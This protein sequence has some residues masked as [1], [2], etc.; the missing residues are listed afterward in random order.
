M[1]NRRLFWWALGGLSAVLSMSAGAALAQTANTAVTTEVLVLTTATEL[2]RLSNRAGIE[3]QNLGPNPIYCAVGS[4]AAAVVNK[5]RQIA[6]T[7]GTWV[8]SA[9]NRT[10]IW[11]VAAT[12]AQVTGAAT[13]VSEFVR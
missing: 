12:A 13:V 8:L 1:M 9:S 4:S 7:G 3:I 11:C 2:P 5:S 6:A 10:R